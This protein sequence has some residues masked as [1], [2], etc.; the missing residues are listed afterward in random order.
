MNK[1]QQ[2]LQNAKSITQDDI[3]VICWVFSF[4]SILYLGLI[5]SDMEQARWNMWEIIAYTQLWSH[6]VLSILFWIFVA[7]TV[8]KIRRTNQRST[9]K[10]SSG[11]FWWLFSAIVI[12]CPACSI[13]IASYLWLGT[14]LV[15][16]PWFWVELKLLWLI[17]L[18]RATWTTLRDLYVCK[19]QK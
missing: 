5:F 8:Y 6:R 2:L 12:W 7:A 9:T 15:N 16:M 3:A 4:W 17:V 10:T 13:S 11:L 14:L 1:R 19:I 18:A